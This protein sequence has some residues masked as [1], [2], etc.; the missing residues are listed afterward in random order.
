MAGYRNMKIEYLADYPEHI[1]ALAKWFHDE[2]GYLSP[3]Y[4]LEERTERLHAKAKKDSIPLALVALESGVPIGSASLVP[5]DMDIRSHLEP[6]LSSVYVEVS[7]RRRGI[8]TALVNRVIQEAQ[9]RGFPSV[10]LWTP[11]EEHFYSQRGWKTLE[12]T[13]YRNETAVVMEHVL[14]EQQANNQ[15]QNTG[16]KAPDSDL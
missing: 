3:N 16:T 11:K 9:Q 13:E 5:C 4:R 1:P 6:W 10:Y 12:R 15:M 8:G 2:W 14:K 7:S